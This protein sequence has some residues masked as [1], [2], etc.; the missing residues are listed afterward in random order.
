MGIAWRQVCPQSPTC[1]PRETQIVAPRVVLTHA[2]L[3]CARGP[4]RPV[5]ADRFALLPH[6]HALQEALRL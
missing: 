1:G 3:P 4:L 6:T 5:L 2:N